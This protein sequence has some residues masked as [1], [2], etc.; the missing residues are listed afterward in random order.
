MRWMCCEGIHI[1]APQLEFGIDME[2][3]VFLMMPQKMQVLARAPAGFLIY[4]HSKHYSSRSC[5]VVLQ[6]VFPVDKSEGNSL[7][8]QA[9]SLH[10]HRWDCVKI[11]G[12][13]P[14]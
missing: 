8:F 1:L 6:K 9:H 14:R 11:S 7:P 3:D 10:H 13:H 2:M 4:A 12:Q 5:L